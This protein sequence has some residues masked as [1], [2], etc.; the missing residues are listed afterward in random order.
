MLI[1]EDLVWNLRCCYGFWIHG[2]Y[3]L[4]REMERMPFYFI[5]KYLRKYGA[6]IGKD[7]RFERGINI[8]RPFGIK[9]FSNLTI[10][11]R[12]YLGHNTIIDLTRPVTIKN[13]V[14][15]ASRVQIWTHASYY[16]GNSVDNLKYGEYKGEITID[17]GALIYS[18]AVLRHGTNIG[19]FSIV[20]ACSMVNRNV[21]PYTF[22]AGVP[23]KLI[24]RN[25]VPEH[26]SN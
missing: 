6:N 7:C 4:A 18:N 9:P 11:D 2:P 16:G 1:I 10:G 13:D 19:T 8:H 20:G 5:V 3:G 17:E 26:S 21:E 24:R 12:V 14:I 22:V 25:E 15:V 23:I